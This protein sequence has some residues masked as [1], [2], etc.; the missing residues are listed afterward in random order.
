VGAA[1]PAL[2]KAL[3]IFVNSTASATSKQQS[4][5]VSELS[6]EEKR[7]QLHRRLKGLVEYAPV[8]LFMKGIPTEPKCK[9]SRRMV[10]LLKE[11]NIAFSSFNILADPEVRAGLKVM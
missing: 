6:A 10:D 8:M 4:A 2:L 7:A 1:A 5:P 3:D 11:A 9:F